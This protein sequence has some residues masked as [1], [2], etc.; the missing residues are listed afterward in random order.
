MEIVN[1]LN[2]VKTLKSARPTVNAEGHAVEWNI[3]VEYSL[4]DYI[5]EFSSNVKIDAPSKAPTDFSKEEL[6]GMC[7][8]S[9]FDVVYESQYT[10]IKLAPEATETVVSD[11]NLDNLK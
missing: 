10:S 6:F 1:T 9:H 5:S 11:F 4:N 3:S 7:N 8:I 2:A